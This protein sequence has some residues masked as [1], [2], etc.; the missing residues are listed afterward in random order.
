MM[1]NIEELVADY[2]EMRRLREDLKSIFERDDGELKDA[3]EAIKVALLAVCN[4]TN[5]NGFKTT[6]GTVT[7]QVKERYFCTD[8]DAF[9]DFIEKEGSIDLL[10][11]R[12]SQKNFKEFMESRENGLPLGVNAMREYDIVVRK[13]SSVSPTLV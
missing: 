1:S 11:R 9:K 5:T 3:M 12:I 2:L 10:E 13:A 6:S 4:D 8:W 7:R